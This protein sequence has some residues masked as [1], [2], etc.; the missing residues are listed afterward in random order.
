MLSFNFVGPFA[1]QL[2]SQ[3]LSY[4]GTPAADDNGGEYQPYSEAIFDVG[5]AR[6]S[7]FGR[8]GRGLAGGGDGDGSSGDRDAHRDGDDNDDRFNDDDG[9]D[10]RSDMGS[11]FTDGEDDP[12]RL[13][14][15][16]KIISGGG[17]WSQAMSAA[18]TGSSP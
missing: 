10:R 6:T 12:D 11:N 1:A 17:P 9:Y 3:F 4:G 7:A 13:V 5:D 2:P 16:D 18:L 14:A 15:I 8:G